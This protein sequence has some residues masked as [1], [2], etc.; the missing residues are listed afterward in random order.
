M[1]LKLV[2]SSRCEQTVWGMPRQK[3]PS[4]R[5][6]QHRPRT[7]KVVYT[8]ISTDHLWMLFRWW[9]PGVIGREMTGKPVPYIYYVDETDQATH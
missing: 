7:V 9:I 1:G 6:A 4:T 3:I 2:K 8:S 5:C